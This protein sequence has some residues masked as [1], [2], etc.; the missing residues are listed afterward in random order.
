[1]EL[2]G[3]DYNFWRFV[4]ELKEKYLN[5]VDGEIPTKYYLFSLIDR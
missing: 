4:K 3:I 1:V 5:K 2:V